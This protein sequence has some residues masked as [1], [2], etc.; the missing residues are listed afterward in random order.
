M[1]KNKEGTKTKENNGV[2]S[3]SG[4]SFGDPKNRS[5]LFSVEISGD[6]ALFSEP[7]S[8]VSGDRVTYPVPT[9]SALAGII[10]AGYWKPTFSLVIDKVRIMNRIRTFSVFNAGEGFDVFYHA[11]GGGRGNDDAP[12]VSSI[13]STLYLSDVSYQVLFH[14]EWNPVQVNLAGDRDF[15]KHDAMMKESLVTGGRLN[16]G[17]GSSECF[18]FIEPCVFGS[19]KGYYDNSGT[20]D[21]G[22]MFHSWRWPNEYPVEPG[23]LSLYR[24]FWEQSM[25]DGI[26]S[27]PRPYDSVPGE[28]DENANS[29][30]LIHEFVRT[31]PRSEHRIFPDKRK[32]IPH[33]KKEGEAA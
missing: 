28:R 10:K 21:F 18:A 24:V 29:G 27:F 20:R 23:R 30:R 17:I 5:R 19:G 3:S 31:I 32:R 7:W 33:G 2:P 15:R 13:R 9:Y 12:P 1:T 26:I 6:K 22:W 4:F 25:T 11:E 8:H 14:Y 16:P